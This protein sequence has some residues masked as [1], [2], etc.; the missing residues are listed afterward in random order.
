MSE[1]S[2]PRRRTFGLLRLATGVLLALTLSPMIASASE[3][4]G[5]HNISCPGVRWHFDDGPG[6]HGFRPRC[7]DRGNS[8]FCFDFAEE[9]IWQIRFIPKGQ[10][11]GTATIVDVKPS[12]PDVVYEL[13]IDRWGHRLEVTWE[14]TSSPV[15]PFDVTVTAEAGNFF[16]PAIELEIDVDAPSSAT[17]ASYEVQFPRLRIES[18]NA[19]GASTI[20]ER[21]VIPIVGGHVLEQ[22]TVSL[23]PGPNGAELVHPGT[24]SMQW[25][26]YYD[27]N[28]EPFLFLGT[29]DSSGYRKQFHLFRQPST[30]SAGIVGFELR[31]KP[32]N[33]LTETDFHSPAP[34]V[35]ACLKGDWFDGAQFYRRWA[36]WQPWAL[37]PGRGPMRYNS[38]FSEL[39]KD[40]EM[41]GWF[42]LDS[43]NPFPPFQ[44]PPCPAPLTPAVKSQYQYWLRNLEDQEDYLGLE[45][46]DI[47]SL[48]YSW[49]SERFDSNLGEWFPPHNEFLAEAGN[50]ALSGRGFAPYFN[51][52]LYS[53]FNATTNCQVLA[54]PGFAADC[55]E[56]FQL[57]TANGI[58]QLST[59]CLGSASQGTFRL[60]YGTEFVPDYATWVAEELEAY[61]STAGGESG[62]RGFYYDTLTH[63]N[64]ELCYNGDPGH[65]G[66]P[67]G[68]G[69]FYQKGKEALV[70]EV[71]NTF[72]SPE[73]GNDPE[74]FMFSEA[75][76]EHFLGLVEIMNV[77]ASIEDTS[78][79]QDRRH[80][81]PLFQTVY[82]EYL[83]A[84]RFDSFQFPGWQ[85]AFAPTP[86]IL[87]T[88]RAYAAH[89]FF[90]HVPWA[91]GPLAPD[92]L[93]TILLDPRYA[94]AAGMIQNFMKYMRQEDVLKYVRFGSRERDPE[95]TGVQLVDRSTSRLLVPYDEIQP[96]V[97]VSAWRNPTWL[98]GNNMGFLLTNWVDDLEQLDI[99]GNIVSGL[100]TVSFTIDAEKHGLWPGLY[101]LSEID[102]QGNEVPLDFFAFTK[103]HTVTIDVP[104][105]EARFITFRR[106]PF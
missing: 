15:G 79:P 21:F 2:F 104:A 22:P 18:P 1:Y 42:S 17:H 94:K 97:Y 23:P 53:I 64:S 32:E 54:V 48:I 7:L 40:S 95:V 49:H 12:N 78:R 101:F 26:G 85:I 98:F 55:A 16:D 60:D 44:Q 41:I 33:N 66:H 76:D 10:M 74:F 96:A 99:D 59:D 6:F 100:Q 82:H 3:A 75:E 19:P 57:L 81:V 73:G 20:D 84:T 93:S 90:G 86:V 30:E 105:R 56:D 39:V 14:I 9:D 52:D 89:L 50:V 68:G 29:R 67:L 92:P 11:P 43:S 102:D 45:Q 46:G 71:K 47:L 65:L 61:L 25:F 106:W 63:L 80:L 4:D 5:P 13:D 34:A 31:I 103:E 58:P 91:G 69:S 8:D 62:L 70:K 72:R 77:N 51:P 88:R 37:G 28:Q 24:L 36:L 27:Q 83:L 35:L 87:E 38:Q